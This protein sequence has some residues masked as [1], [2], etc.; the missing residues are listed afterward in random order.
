MSKHFAGRKDAERTTGLAYLLSPSRVQSPGEL[1]FRRHGY[2][3]CGFVIGMLLYFVYCNPEYS[4]TYTALRQR[5][6]WDMKES[7]F[8][9][10]LTLQPSRI[11]RPSTAGEQQPPPQ[12]SSPLRSSAAG[13]EENG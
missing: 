5:C 12:S 3:R 7:M 4:Y 11:H 8:P 9:Q 13:T 1:R 6:G 2:V 10:Y